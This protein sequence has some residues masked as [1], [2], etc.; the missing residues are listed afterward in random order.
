MVATDLRAAGIAVVLANLREFLAH[1]LRQTLRTGENIGQISDVSQKLAVFADDLLLLE[2]RQPIQAHV[3][4]GL[5]LRFG[6]TISCRRQPQICRKAAG[7]RRDAAGTRQQFWHDA[8]GPRARLQGI[9]RRGG[10]GRG[11]DYCNDRVDIG[12]RHGEA[13]ENMGALARFRKVVNR[14]P[15]DDFAPMANERF[16]NLLQRQKFWLAVLQRHHVD[17]EHRFHR[18]LRIEIVEYNLGNFAALEFDDDAHAV[19]VG[20]VAQLRDAI[21][22]FGAHQIRD[23]LEQTRLI[24][25]I[26]QLGDDDGLAVGFA[27]VL[28][29]RTAA[30]RQAPATGAIGGRNLLR[31]VDDAGGGK[32]RTRYVLHQRRERQR[33]V[34][35]QRQ[36]RADNLGEVVR[37]NVGGHADRNA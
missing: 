26:R 19:L 2:S 20:L 27:D 10:R 11:F 3:E 5:R 13:L 22:V 8:G 33:W 12:E 35:K 7:A 28:K 37:R 4:N 30:D 1:D 36:T 17:A 14:A 21:D 15:R 24:H 25:L 6:E 31:T 9:A 34:V 23:T 16:Q 32:I 29:M 18:R